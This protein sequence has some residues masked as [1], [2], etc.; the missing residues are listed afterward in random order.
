M[1]EAIKAIGL[2][3]SVDRYELLTA[4]HRPIRPDDI[5]DSTTGNADATLYLLSHAAGCGGLEVP[6]GAPSGFWTR[7]GTHH[8][9]YS[10]LGLVLGLITIITGAVLFGLGV[11][12]KT[13]WVAHVLGFESRI[14]DAAPGAL[15][16]VAG[17]LIV[18]ITKY[19]V[20][21]GARRGQP[22]A[23]ER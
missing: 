13:T 19:D 14:S 4:D 17:V 12:G 9:I 11:G 3:G 18:W 1:Q 8:F 21:V 16:F 20:R 2:S 10:V 5:L 23:K 15:L 7:A 22:K 6:S